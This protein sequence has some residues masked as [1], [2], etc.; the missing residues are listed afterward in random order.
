M[1]PDERL[2]GLLV[3]GGAYVKQSQ[4]MIDAYPTRLR[5]S[6]CGGTGR[7]NKQHTAK[8]YVVDKTRLKLES[9]RKAKTHVRGSVH[10]IG[11]VAA[12]A[13]PAVDVRYGQAVSVLRTVGLHGASER[14]V[15]EGLHAAGVLQIICGA[16]IAQKRK[17]LWSDATEQGGD[18][19]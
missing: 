10:L 7:H 13:A 11:E 15:H 4:E 16:E 12:E 17:Q 19:V 18:A 9:N 2:I 5:H 1:R 8:K 6:T 14:G 3:G